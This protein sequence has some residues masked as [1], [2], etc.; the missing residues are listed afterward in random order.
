MNLHHTA[1]KILI[2][3]PSGCGKT[4]FACKHIEAWPADHVWIFDPQLEFSQRLKVPTV[5][6]LEGL[7]S[8]AAAG[9]IV[10]W[11]PE[12]L[13]RGKVHNAFAAFCAW[14]YA[15]ACRINGPKLLVLD[16]IQRY[17][18]TGQGGIP[19]SLADVMHTGRRQELDLLITSQAPNLVHDQIRLQLTETYAF[20]FQ[21][22]RQLE[23]L[24]ASGIPSES[25]RNTPKHCC[26]WLKSGLPVMRI[27]V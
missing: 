3:G 2:T 27:A 4:T 8:G 24:E 18:R 14:A 19:D 25:V 22:R 5:S 12:P 23:W 21:D 20:A 16:E 7:A 1:S 26:I 6:T 11:D 17:T 13:Y 9:G 15:V 10:C